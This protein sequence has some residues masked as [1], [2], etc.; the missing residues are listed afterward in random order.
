MI[1]ISV[2]LIL[3]FSHFIADFMLQ[4]DKM[5]LNKSSSVKWLSIHL[6][7][8]TISLYFLCLLFNEMFNANMV[9]AFSFFIVN[10][11]AHWLTDFVT[12]RATTKLWQAGQRHWFFVVIGLDQAIHAATLFLTYTLITG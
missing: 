8:Y 4:T 10:G 5:A 1:P 3:T 2:I 9:I 12:S 6:S 11:L 7:V